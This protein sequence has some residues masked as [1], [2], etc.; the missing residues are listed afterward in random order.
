MG[1]LPTLY[2][3]VAPD[4]HG[5]DYYG[6]GGFQELGGY[7]RK[8]EST[9]RAKLDDVAANLWDISEEMTGVH[10]LG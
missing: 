5:N 7:P 8:V 1:A 4:V 9:M 2:A 3:A 10:Y 6:P